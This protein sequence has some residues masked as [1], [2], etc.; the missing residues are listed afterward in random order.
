MTPVRRMNSAKRAVLVAA[1]ASCTALGGASAQWYPRAAVGASRS[2]DLT[3]PAVLVGVRQAGF[4]FVSLGA[5]VGYAREAVDDTALNCGN[6]G[7]TTVTARFRL[8]TVFFMFPLTLGVPGR[9]APYVRAGPFLSV[10]IRCRSPQTLCDQIAIPQP[11]Y[12]GALGL[13]ILVRRRVLGVEARYHRG[14]GLHS[15]GG[16]GVGSTRVNQR[17][18][19]LVI[20][21]ALG[22]AP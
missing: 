11:G 7:C 13:A 19:T 8:N 6:G 15:I 9:I 21:L 17:P 14:L 18:G 5:E 12:F 4:R 2:R 3:G 10:A 20:L 1:A 16:G 22:A